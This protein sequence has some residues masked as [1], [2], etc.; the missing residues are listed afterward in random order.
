M[1]Y[2]KEELKEKILKTIED[3]P[4]SFSR[5]LKSKKH[6]IS[7]LESL[8]FYY[9]QL[10][11]PFYTVQTKIYWLMND[12][13][14]F[15][16]CGNSK[17]SNTFEHRNVK[18]WKYGYHKNCCPQ[19]G[20]DSEER[21]RLYVEACKKKYGVENISQ[22]EKTKEKK[23]QKALERYGVDNVA[24]AQEVKEDIFK[25]NLERYG[26]TTYLHSEQGEKHKKKTC[27]ERYG[28]D[29]FSKTSM[30]TEMM[31]AANRKN[32]GVD[33]PQ[34]NRDFMRQMQKRYAFNGLNFDSLPEL[35][36]YIWCKDNS[37]DFV[38]QPN[39]VFCYEYNGVRHTYEPDF[40]IEGKIIE[41]KGDQFF[42]EDGTMQN[43]YD[44]SQDEI[45]EAK[46]QCMLKNNVEIW[47]YEKYSKCIDYIDNKYG[48]D[49]LKSFKNN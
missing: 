26:A 43:P 32:Y 11:D 20:K 5:I 9:P 45:Y 10:R 27:L 34:Q 21:K 12:L 7:I 46:H 18:N 24:K 17:C 48:K 41:I 6:D 23:K 29:S 44:H 3:F 4:H 19:C 8:D 30:H 25:T 37:I 47:K 38:Y 42:K 33:W 28:V 35:A 22:R 16:K 40:M 13:K 15:P 2:S 39:V 1:I 31:K 49:Y 36:V 14:E